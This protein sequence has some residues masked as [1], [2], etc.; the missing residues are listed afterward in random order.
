MA[1]R[2]KT[3]DYEHSEQQTLTIDDYLPADH[4]ARFI[5]GIGDMLDLEVFYAYYAPQGGEP[6]GPQVLGGLLVYGY[7]TRVFSTRRIEQA[8]YEVM[9]FRLIAGG[10]HPDH[11]TIA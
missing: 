7:A 4:L 11:S 1:R 3:V 5:V 9:P 2:F 10:R 8:T 6:I